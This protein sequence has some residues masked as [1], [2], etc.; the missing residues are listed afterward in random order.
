VLVM[1]RGSTVADDDIA[2]GSVAD[3]CLHS[4]VKQTSHFKGVTTV[5]DPNEHCVAGRQL[6]SFSLAARTQVD[7]FVH[8]GKRT[9]FSEGRCVGASSLR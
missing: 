6:C 8:D 2:I 5:F 1:D 7:S 4:G 3:R 9:A